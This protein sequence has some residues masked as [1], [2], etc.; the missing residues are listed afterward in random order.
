MSKPDDLVSSLYDAM[1]LDLDGTVYHGARS[2]PGVAETVRKL[3]E[4]GNRVRFVTN[5]ASK[6]PGEVAGNLRGMAIDAEAAEVSTSAQAGARL[7]AERLS[8]GTPVLVVGAPALV[9]E[10]EAAGLRAVR[11]AGDGVAAVVQ[12]HWTET[13][14]RHLAEASVAIRAGALWVA[15]NVDATLPTERGQ[16]PGN[17]SMVMALR[18]ATGAEPEVAGKPAAPLLRT[19]A[20]SAGAARALVVG[21]RLDTD[22]AGA[23][24]AG[25]D[26]LAVLTGVATPAGLLAAGPAE[27]PRY[28]AADLTALIEPASALAVGPREGWRV[29]V[30]GG[31]LVAASTGSTDALDLL[32]ALC[33]LAWESGHTEVGAA[34]DRA[35]LAL[36]E[37]GLASGA[38][39]IG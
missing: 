8:A 2:I 29:T 15:C 24:A 5:N 28:L 19:A 32:R 18:T 30:D 25:L 27:R 11:E 38:A 26:S 6:A 39:A 13:G 34:D 1:L 20:A 10:V 23:V 3:R 17:G 14:W 7:L 12:G 37:L 35:A 4:R 16:L 31:R 33:G 22:I 21:D 9:A 36:A